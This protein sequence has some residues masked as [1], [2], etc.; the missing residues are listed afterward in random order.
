M[1]EEIAEICVASLLYTEYWN[2]SDMPDMINDLHLCW[3]PFFFFFLNRPNWLNLCRFK[4]TERDLNWLK[5]EIICYCKVRK[6]FNNMILTQN[7]IYSS[8][9]NKA[10]SLHISFILCLLWTEW[11]FYCSFCIACTLLHEIKK[12]WDNFS[13]EN[14]DILL[15]YH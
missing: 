1:A 3:W 15:Y 8:S 5:W 11:A 13:K 10:Y 4:C 12:R 14:L 9:D 7:C 2:E 6:L